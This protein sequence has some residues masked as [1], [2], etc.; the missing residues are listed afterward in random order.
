MIVTL[1]SASELTDISASLKQSCGYSSM[2][3]W[4][5]SHMISDNQF[6]IELEVCFVLLFYQ[7]E[8][9]V[10]IPACIEFF[11]T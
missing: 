8:W 11:L 2:M 4:S 5:R 9:N 7:N 3:N 1:S 6:V 10:L